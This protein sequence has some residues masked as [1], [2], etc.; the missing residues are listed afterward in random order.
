MGKN[1]RKRGTNL[2]V[3][4]YAAS[5]AHASAR[6]NARRPKRSS[7]TVPLYATAVVVLIIVVLVV[8][9]TLKSSPK[10]ATSKTSAQTL[11]TITKDLRNVPTA[12]L[13]SVTSKSTVGI[14]EG[15]AAIKGTSPLL[16]SSSDTKPGVLYVGAEYCPY[17]AAERWP[18]VIA[19]DRF[20]SFTGLST[21]R[22][23]STDKYPNTATL[24]FRNAVYTSAYLNFQS[25]ETTTN[26]PNA[27][28]TGYTTLQTPTKFENTLLT[29]Y[30]AGQSIPFLDIDNLFAS[31]GS[32]YSPA[33]LKGYTQLEIATSIF[34]PTSP[35]A[36]VLAPSV[37]G[38]ANDI[39][40]ALCQATKQQPS[41]VCNSPSVKN[42]T[43]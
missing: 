40:K 5:Q 7:W 12:V 8:A 20:G 39:T 4:Q 37:V 3:K 10:Q 27:S 22:S 28:G 9:S 17:C 34:D 2:T 15:P 16:F 23:S 19:L 14:V 43:A 38:A 25:V 11:A 42:A 24:S 1:D 29:K 30:D 6:S 41:N 33:T 13:N 21:T 26:V 36:S 32:N 18:L 31:I 35:F